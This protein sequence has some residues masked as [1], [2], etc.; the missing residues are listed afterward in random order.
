M[1]VYFRSVLSLLNLAF[2]FC[3]GTRVEGNRTEAA[4]S[5][6]LSEGQRTGSMPRGLEKHEK[7]RAVGAP[8]PA[9]PP[10]LSRSASPQTQPGPAQSRAGGTPVKASLPALVLPQ[11]PAQGRIWGFGVLSNCGF[12]NFVSLPLNAVE[13]QEFSFTCHLHGN[14]YC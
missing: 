8:I 2:C 4:S 10:V 3:K 9:A 14:D 7:S 1:V 11:S 6:A 13:F 12:I 5:S